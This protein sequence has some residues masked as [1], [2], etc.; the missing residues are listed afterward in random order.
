ML[1]AM[2]LN[3]YGVLVGR[4]VDCRREGG[5]DS[6]H[7]QVRI[8]HRR[9]LARPS[10][11]LSDFLD[12]YVKRAIAD[13]GALVYAFGERWG[14][15]GGMKDKAFRMKQT[16]TLPPGPLAAGES[17][18][19]RRAGARGGLDGHVLILAHQ[20]SRRRVCTPA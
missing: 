2:P 11:D 12:H 10:D 13:P 14:P 18:L 3:K 4:A 15:E 9:G 7:Y 16:Y 20:Y 19:H 5:P 1:R 17:R 8:G 6:P